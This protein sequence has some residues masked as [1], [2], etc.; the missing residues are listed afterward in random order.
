MFTDAANTLVKGFSEKRDLAAHFGDSFRGMLKKHK[1]LAAEEGALLDFIEATGEAL[2]GRE[3]TFSAFKQEYDGLMKHI[4]EVVSPVVERMTGKP[5][6]I[7]SNFVHRPGSYGDD[8]NGIIEEF[9]TSVRAGVNKGFTKARTLED[10]TIPQGL[11][12]RTTAYINK[13]SKLMGMAQPV[14]TFNMLA[15]EFKAAGKMNYHAFFKR[16]ALDAAGTSGALDAT[17]F[18]QLLPGSDKIHKATSNFF[19]NVL[20]TVP[21]GVNQLGASVLSI[22]FMGLGEALNVVNYATKEIARSPVKLIKNIFRTGAEV[23]ADERRVFDDPIL[24]QI[25]ILRDSVESRVNL[26]QESR[27]SIT[28]K[29]FGGFFSRISEATMAGAAKEAYKGAIANGANHEVAISF[30]NEVALR[31]N[32]SMERALKAKLATMGGV[33]MLAPLQGFAF[34]AMNTMLKDGLLSK[35]SAAEKLGVLGKMMAANLY[36]N[37]IT[38][39][40]TGR[41][42]DFILDSIPLAQTLLRGQVGGPILQA[43]ETA[44]EI[45]DGKVYPAAKSLALMSTRRIPVAQ[46]IK[47]AEG[48]KNMLVGDNQDP[49]QLLMG[50]IRPEEE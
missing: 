47:T 25:S 1:I 22:V 12:D 38:G 16:V 11:V 39:T 32:G 37:M 49:R 13:V 31:T 21:T 9:K 14:E 27:V 42:K 19:S 24:N 46:I 2:P 3:K 41:D 40:L 17:A 20:A 18:R 29:T 26:M 7:R 45:P 30:A 23:I 15:D 6:N 44:K 4:A 36:V 8:L 43:I 35:M 50:K 33:K 28:D 5:L 10:P 48:A 34:T